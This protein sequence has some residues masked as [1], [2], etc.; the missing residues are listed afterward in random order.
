MKVNQLYLIISSVVLTA[1]KLRIMKLKYLVK[2]SLSF[3]SIN[4]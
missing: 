4:L 2:A 1:H 3:K